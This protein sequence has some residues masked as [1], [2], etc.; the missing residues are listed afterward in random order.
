[1][2]TK[3]AFTNPVSDQA[4]TGTKP[5]DWNAAHVVEGVYD[6]KA[7]GATGNGSTDDHA[8][9]QSAIDACAAAGGGIVHM[10]PGVYNTGTTG[11][12]I[13]GSNIIL[14][15]SGYLVTQL[16]YS[17]TGAAVKNSNNT[18]E[19][20]WCILRDF[21]I[22]ING[23]TAT[24]ACALEVENF[25]HSNFERLYFHA[26]NS[27]Y[28]VDTVRMKCDN[29]KKTYFDSF[30]DCVWQCYKGVALRITGYGQCNRHFFDNCNFKGDSGSTALQAIVSDPANDNQGGWCFINTSIEG[31]NSANPVIY[32]GY[33]GTN[34]HGTRNNLFFGL[35]L[36]NC[37]SAP[38]NTLYSYYNRIIHYAATGL[39]WIDDEYLPWQRSL[40]VDHVENNSGPHTHMGPMPG[41]T[42]HYHD[43]V[44][45]DSD[46]TTPVDGQ[47]IV[48]S[49]DSRLYIRIEGV[50]K[51][52]PLAASPKPS[53]SGSR[54]G[55]AALASLLT[56]LA[57]L[58]L[59][60]D[61]TGS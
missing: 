1:M 2:T 30:R 34:D 7:Y 31:Y 14:Q 13:S 36:E 8:A 32:L 54:G 25:V 10:P 3:H 11:I 19:R 18:A 56:A 52:I 40:E 50:W 44:P 38:R 16:V 27:T 17:G 45:T 41:F 35:F 6:I 33:T 43:N 5:S 57:G 59:I 48:D 29:T 21:E 9:I 53:V 4:I 37:T 24:T 60:T 46:E 15:G 61:S 47:A 42:F 23:I 20:W 12:G 22:D 55:N 28:A 39:E 26:M 51:G 49:A 58:G